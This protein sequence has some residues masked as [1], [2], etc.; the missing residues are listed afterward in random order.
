MLVYIPTPCGS[1]EVVAQQQQQQKTSNRMMMMM[2][3]NSC[4]K[5]CFQLSYHHTVERLATCDPQ[6]IRQSCGHTTQW[7]AASIEL[8]GLLAACA[9]CVDKVC[10]QL[11]S[12][13]VER[14]GATG[15]AAPASADPPAR[16]GECDS[17]ARLT[18]P[19]L[20]CAD[21]TS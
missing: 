4:K 3:V 8:I 14:H 12:A 17:S 1:L 2:V 10:C 5:G 13:A 16:S 19:Q 7:D 18:A 11:I 21:D 15:P 9:T 6:K 20:S